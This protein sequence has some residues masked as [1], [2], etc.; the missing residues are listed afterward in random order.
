MIIGTYIYHH[1]V[2]F[3]DKPFTGG[4]ALSFS[5]NSKKHEPNTS[6]DIIIMLYNI[7]EF[8]IIQTIFYIYILEINC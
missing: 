8:R 6:T 3:D 7:S 1:Y 5:Q 4:G 2:I